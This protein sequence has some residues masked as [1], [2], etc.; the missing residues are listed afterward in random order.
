MIKAIPDSNF[1]VAVFDERDSLAGKA[2]PLWDA[3][4]REGA[5]F[6][7][8]DCI[9]N[10]VISTLCR[11]F[12]ERKRLEE[13][14][15]IF[16]TLKN[17]FTKDRLVWGY[18]EVERLYTGIIDLIGEH[19][20]RLNFHDA[21][22]ALLAKEQHIQYLISFDNDFDHISWLIRI[23]DIREIPG[24]QSGSDERLRNPGKDNE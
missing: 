2:R 23:G 11:R 6:F 24:E 18:R 1:L 13:W 3:L 7:Y 20:G 8:L 10:E 5:E 14:P 19:G 4:S 22:I 15:E 9:V 17:F 21:L 16:Q 12:E